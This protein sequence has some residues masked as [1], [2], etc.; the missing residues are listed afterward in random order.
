[1]P[2][3]LSRFSTLQLALG[4]SIAVHAALLTVRFVAPAAFDRI[5]EDTPLEVILVNAKGS[6]APEKAQA[7]AQTALAGGGDAEKGRATSPLPNATL[8]TAGD[9][10]ENAQRQM[11]QLQQEQQ[12]LLV[13]VRRQLAS[14]PVPDPRQ[15]R[16]S[17][18]GRAQEE[19]RQQL[20]RLLAE[21]E[22]RIHEENAR[23]RKRYISPATREVAYALYYDQ[24]R[25]K[26]ED[27]GTRN[28]PEAHGKKLYGELVMVLTV[29]HDGR[30]LSTEIVQ[31]SGNPLLDGRAEAI[32]RAAGPF[33]PFNAEMRAKSEQLAMV[34]RFKFTRDQVLEAQLK[35]P[36]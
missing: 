21:I 31:S 28:F 34:A 13:Q 8:S 12:Q 36:Q 27:K 16:Q 10:I 7:V 35:E 24:L 32:A 14:M 19:K 5:F 1:M 11:E 30:V 6:E 33:G 2:G 25:R 17:T 9:E 15:P 26:V 4:I 22:K 23:P 18:E 20:I 3:F 29:N